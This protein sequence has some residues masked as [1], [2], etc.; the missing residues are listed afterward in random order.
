MNYLLV[1]MSFLAYCLSFGQLKAKKQ[2]HRLNPA[3][4]NWLIEL[5]K[6]QLNGDFDGD[7]V[8]EILFESLISRSTGIQIDSLRFFGDYDN[9]NKLIC[10]LDP[11]LKLKS[12]SK[13][14]DLNLVE[15]CQTFGI[16]RI[17]NLGNVNKTPGDEIALIIN[18]ADWS[19]CNSCRIY[20]FNLEW[21]K[22]ISFEIHESTVFLNEWTDD[23]I[24]GVIEKESDGWYYCERHWE[25]GEIWHKLEL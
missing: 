23:E 2:I 21:K 12:K 13:K 1:G 8:E 18:W 3:R 19:N 4:N 6:Q 5:P 20:S 10:D 22:E 7:G 11:E 17:I 25:L 15:H 14:F 9:R 24:K 16:L